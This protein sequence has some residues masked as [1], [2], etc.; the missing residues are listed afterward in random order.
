MAALGFDSDTALLVPLLP[1]IQVAWADG[2][3]SYR[4]E[5]A[6]KV[7]A[8]RRGLREGTPAYERFEEYLAAKPKDNVYRASVEALKAIYDAM[9]L[10]EAT[11]TKEQMAADCF[12]V[13]D[14]SGGFMLM[15]NRLCAEEKELLVE[16]FEEL[17]IKESEALRKLHDK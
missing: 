6:L 11:A 3:S 12:A 10:A 16:L 14:A 5:S 2:T 8:H 1:V 17:D 15:G 7:I 13:A 4:E 9:D